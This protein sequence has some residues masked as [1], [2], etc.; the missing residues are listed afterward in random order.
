MSPLV[1]RS[2]LK[3]FLIV[4]SCTPLVCVPTTLALAQR[5]AVGTAGGLSLIHISTIKRFPV[6]RGV[7]PD[8][9]RSAPNG[10][11]TSSMVREWLA[12]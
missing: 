10:M 8:V 4:V 2:I 1:R 3:K 11:L 9:Q 6:V 5:P 12:L 7:H